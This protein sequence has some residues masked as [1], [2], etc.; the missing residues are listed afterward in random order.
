MAATTDGSSVAPASAPD[1]EKWLPFCK[2][3]PKVE[4]HAHLNGS[5]RDATIRELADKRGPKGLLAEDA[6]T[7]TSKGDRSLADCFKLFDVIHQ[8]TTEHDTIT[9]ITREVVADFAADSVVYLELRTTPKH[10]PEVGMTKQSYVEAVLAGLMDA[11]IATN[12]DPPQPPSSQKAEMLEDTREATSRSNGAKAATFDE[13]RT[14]IIVGLILSIDRRESGEAAL[15]TVQLA[16]SLRHRGVVGIDLSGNPTVGSWAT[17]LPALQ[18]ARAYGL[19]LTLHCG[20]VPNAEEVRAMLAFRPERVGHVCCLAEPEWQQLLD[21]KIPVEA[22]LTSN[23]KTESISSFAA[24]HFALLY[25]DD[26]P[27]AICTDDS[28]VFSTSLSQEYAIVAASFGLT[29]DHV[30]SVARHS[31]EYIFASE[32]VKQ[33]LRRTFVRGQTHKQ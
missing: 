31:V 26:H 25:K 2:Q 12:D 30:F 13:R 6:H 22:C 27:V 5:I 28:G 24:H 11:K 7:L 21:A 14:G 16:H 15:E 1:W 4:L 32:S 17:F 3:L 19:P 9:R 18:W 20:E 33:K 23:I 29:A 8:L 10:R